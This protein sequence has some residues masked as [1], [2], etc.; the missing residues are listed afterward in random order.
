MGKGAARH[1]IDMDCQPLPGIDWL[2]AGAF[3]VGV[4]H[5]AVE[6]GALKIAKAIAVLVDAGLRP[7]D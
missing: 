3:S 1:A 4:R 7:L 6:G 2:A 5:L